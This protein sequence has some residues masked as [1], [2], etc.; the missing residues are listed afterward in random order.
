MFTHLD[1]WIIPDEKQPHALWLVMIHVISMLCNESGDANDEEVLESLSNKLNDETAP[2]KLALLLIATK[3]SYSDVNNYEEWFAS[4]ANIPEQLVAT[5]VYLQ[6]YL[7]NLKA[8]HESDLAYGLPQKQRDDILDSIATCFYFYPTQE[9]SSLFELI[10]EKKIVYRSYVICLEDSQR[11]EIFHQGFRKLTKGEKPSFHSYLSKRLHRI[12][13]L[14]SEMGYHRARLIKHFIDFMQAATRT[15]EQAATFLLTLYNHAE[16]MSL[17][18]YNAK[19]VFVDLSII[20]PQMTTEQLIDAVL[21]TF[22][23]LQKTGMYSPWSLLSAKDYCTLVLPERAIVAQYTMQHL[24]S[25]VVCSDISNLLH[26]QL[27]WV[28]TNVFVRSRV[29][30]SSDTLLSLVQFMT[31]NISD[32]TLRSFIDRAA[33]KL[34]QPVSRARLERGLLN[35]VES[36]I[37]LENTHSLRDTIIRCFVKLLDCEIEVAMPFLRLSFLDLVEL[38]KI[39]FVGVNLL[40]ILLSLYPNKQQQRL[41]LL[42]KIVKTRAS[43]LG[44]QPTVTEPEYN[45]VIFSERAFTNILPPHLLFY[46]LVCFDD[47]HDFYESRFERAGENIWEYYTKEDIADRCRNFIVGFPNP[48]VLNLKIH[49]DCLCQV[50]CHDA[51]HVKPFAE[52]LMQLPNNIKE[53]FLSIYNRQ[54]YIPWSALE[55]FFIFTRNINQPAVVKTLSRVFNS[56]KQFFNNCSQHNLQ[57]HEHDYERDD[58]L[59]VL[60]YLLPIIHRLLTSNEIKP[61]AL[62]F[63]LCDALKTHQI[64]PGDED[65][66][67]HVISLI[68]PNS[69]NHIDQ[70]LTMLSL[71]YKSGVEYGYRANFDSSHI[72]DINDTLDQLKVKRRTSKLPSSEGDSMR[73]FSKSRQSEITGSDLQH[74]I[75]A[76]AK[77]LLDEH[78]ETG[79]YAIEKLRE[80][81]ALAEQMQSL[82][83][84]K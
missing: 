67:L 45:T 81:K 74:Q 52:Q 53:Q 21:L 35:L 3:W 28:V 39:N 24:M 50:D 36:T 32:E 78:C 7:D 56:T 2:E 75:S 51:R 30:P 43:I 64:C 68:D 46:T 31:F 13:E 37:P 80:M 49:L 63:Q 48:E 69:V 66:N 79:E 71:L 59:A 70:V 4:T 29:Q 23:L 1:K 82:M 54:T 57:T 61:T 34:Y 58:V 47:C 65:F 55:K 11:F 27:A 42:K 26:I 16:N 9:Q 77:S 84:P 19:E 44:I 17:P 73:L 76:M 60:L 33:M 25:H 6:Q 41:D 72:D 14:L 38:Q 83:K 15:R 10:L 22:R 8:L 18:D 62:I 5:N 20:P 12:C 40:E